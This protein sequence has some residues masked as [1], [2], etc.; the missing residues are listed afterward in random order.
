[1]ENYEVVHLTYYDPRSPHLIMADRSDKEFVKYFYCSNKNNC[2]L[3]KSGACV[4]RY[5]L[6]GS[7]CPYGKTSMVEGFTR[8]ARKC[9]KL[10]QEAKSKYPDAVSALDVPRHI[11][12]VGD[13]VFVTLPFLYDVP[14]PF[15]KHDDEIWGNE[16]HL[17][18][19]DVFTPELIVELI[20]YKPQAW[21]GGGTIGDYRQKHIPEFCW[22]LKKYM[23]DMFDRVKAIYPEIKE[24]ADISFVGK[25]AKLSTLKNGRIRMNNDTFKWDGK[26]LTFVYAKY[27]VPWGTKGKIYIEPDESDVV[28]IIDND[29]VDENTE[30]VD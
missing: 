5:G 30:F 10:V 1:M 15:R 20:N 26:K 18:K 14:V 24:I 25:K 17:I 21:F 23:P 19:K 22:Q 9:G 4:M 27:S 3:Y 11:G 13:Y 7:K 29:T 28:E 6:W 8:A 2:E 16:G 12:Y